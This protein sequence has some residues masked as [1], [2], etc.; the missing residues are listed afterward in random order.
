M[1]DK[2][3]YIYDSVASHPSYTS[4]MNAL[5]AYFLKIDCY[6]PSELSEIEMVLYHEIAYKKGYR[7]KQ[8]YE[9][10]KEATNELNLNDEQSNHLIV[11][12]MSGFYGIPLVASLG[13]GSNVK[14]MFENYLNKITPEVDRY[15]E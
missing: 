7:S 11:N 1:R 13:F 12:F 8:L 10:L 6:S 9:I 3:K 14:A 2:L 4:I 15:E 5:T